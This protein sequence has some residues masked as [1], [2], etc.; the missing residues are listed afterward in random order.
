[1]FL[2][3]FYVLVDD[4]DVIL[5]ESLPAFDWSLFAVSASGEETSCRW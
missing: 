2:T 1:M 4:G 5:L 3:E